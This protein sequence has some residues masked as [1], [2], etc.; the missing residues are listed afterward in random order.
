MTQFHQNH[1]RSSWMALSARFS[2]VTWRPKPQKYN[3]RRC[4]LLG[5]RSVN[6]LPLQRIC[7]QKSSN[8]LRYATALWTRVPNSREAVFFCFV[9]EKRLSRRIQLRRVSRVSRC[10]SAKTWAW[11]QRNWIGSCWI[12]ARK[13]WGGSKKT[14]CVIWSYNETVITPLPG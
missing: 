10:Q 11:E 2:T 6:T 14:S 8:F 7:K 4:P 9:R 12:M 3:Q 5:N 1:V 13:E